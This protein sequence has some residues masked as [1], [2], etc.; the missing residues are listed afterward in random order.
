V[1]STLK[2]L[3]VTPDYL[4]YHF[5]WQHTDSGQN[6]YAGSVDSDPLILQVAGNPS[7]LNWSDWASA[8]ASL[9]QQLTDYM[10]TGTS[11]VELCVTENNSDSGSMGRQSTS[12]V[13]ALYLADSTCQLMETEFRS[14]IWWDLHNGPDTTGD[15]DQTIYGWRTS[16]DYGILSGSDAPYPS[17][18]AAKLLQSFAR[19][20]DAVLASAS[21]NLLLSA[22]AVRRTNGAMTMLVVNKDM[23]TNLMGQITLTNFVPWSTATMQSYGLPQDAATQTNGPAA[24]QDLATNSYP[25]AA[26]SFS[27]N[28]PPLSLTLFTFAP[29]PALLSVQSAQPSQVNLL[30]Q[31]QSGAPYIIQSS[32]NLPG[33]WTSVSTNMLIGSSTN[34]PVTITP[35]QPVQF[36]RAIWQQ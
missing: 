29:G 22:Y 12:L 25:S 33:H 2:S 21:D 13:N 26:A 19:P 36:Y 34:I 20:G 4:I 6:Y 32:P 1:L 24:S 28:F 23:V 14:Y 3:G 15:F 5:Y 27:Y 18:Y 30:L 17:F 9:R 10:G 16:G 31:G 35:G 8:A 11:N 7:P